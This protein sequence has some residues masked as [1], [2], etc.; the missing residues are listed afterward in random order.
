[1]GKPLTA[2]TATFAD[3]GSLSSWAV[4][5][6]GQM[7]ATGVMTG[8]GENT[9]APKSDYTREQSIITILRLYNLVK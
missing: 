3:T 2:G 6:V 8:V 7:Q 5:P 1:M 9:F 4:E